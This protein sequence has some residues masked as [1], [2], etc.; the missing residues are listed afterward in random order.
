MRIV[1]GL[2]L[3]WLLMGCS[4]VNDVAKSAPKDTPVATGIPLDFSPGLY[5]LSDT[6]VSLAYFRPQPLIIDD[7]IAN[8]VSDSVSLEIY[9]SKY[10]VYLATTD[11]TLESARFSLFGGSTYAYDIS[12]SVYPGNFVY[13]LYTGFRFGGSFAKIGINDGRIVLDSGRYIVGYTVVMC[14]ICCCDDIPRFQMMPQNSPNSLEILDLGLQ[15]L[16][17]FE[18]EVGDGIEPESFSCST[19][20][21]A[22]KLD[23][24]VNA[25]LRRSHR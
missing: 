15:R 17:V 7:H 1:L 14:I 9:D 20:T 2:L 21:K 25:S 16:L 18:R 5:S 13:D 3:A 12:N 8:F 10:Y 11:G 22:C 4:A 19:K 24:K 23:Y 6:S